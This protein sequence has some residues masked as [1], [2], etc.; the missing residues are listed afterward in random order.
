MRKVVIRNNT[1]EI[2]N[3]IKEFQPNEEWT[4]PSDSPGL[5]IKYANHNPLLI[6]IAN[7]EASI[8]DS[9]KFFTTIAEQMHWLLGSVPASVNTTS[10]LI[11]N[12][13]QLKYIYS[14]MSGFVQL[15][16]VEFESYYYIW[17]MV[18]NQKLFI[19]QLTKGSNECVDFENTAKSG[20][21]QKEAFRTRITTCKIGRTLHDR[22]I[23]F[24]TASQDDYDNTDFKDRDFNDVVY[25]MKKKHFNE[26]TG[27]WEWITTLDPAECDET[28]L[29]WE[30]THTFEI[31]G[32][33]LD[34]PSAL[35][36]D[37]NKWEGHV[38][39]LPDIPEVLGGE[40]ILISNPR[41]K[42]KKNQSLF[43]DASL[44]PKELQYSSVYHT[45]KI[46]T[47]IKHPRG[48]QVEFQINFKI[49]K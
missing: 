29:D 26:S 16:Y 12:W 47:I 19:P 27:Q 38:V 25:W 42:F 3:W 32:G 24:K 39:A 23:T 10:E 49:F 31:Y 44:N 37:E 43:I 34:I 40:I 21:N 7:E 36:G 2:K 17:S 45:N 35:T 9:E 14:S 6:A 18:N 30:C 20:A 22:Y 46:R 15:Y 1:S 11:V 48:E 4:I 41:L 13:T 28:W 8:G 5:A 33:Y